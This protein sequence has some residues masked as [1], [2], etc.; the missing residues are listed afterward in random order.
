VA[1]APKLNRMR[2]ERG[3]DHEPGSQEEQPGIRNP[4]DE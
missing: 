3:N 4:L 1:I 2:R